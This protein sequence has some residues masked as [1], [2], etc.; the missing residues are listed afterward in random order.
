MMR[1]A[2]RSLPEVFP[3]SCPRFLSPALFAGLLLSAAAQAADPPK[4]AAGKGKSLLMSRAELRECMA[5]QDRVQAKARELEKVKSELAGDKQDI[6]RRGDELK[7]QLAGLDRTSQEQVDKYNAQA[8]DRDQR[9]DAYQARSNAFNG[10]VDALNAQRDTWTRTCANRR[11][12]EADEI[13]IKKEK[14]P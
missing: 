1:A 11:F 13:A 5:L 7:E 10:E 14:K 8:A 3:M 4:G 2:T 12:D 9:I 6:A